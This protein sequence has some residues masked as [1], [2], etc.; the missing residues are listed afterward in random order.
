[1]A[2]G[3]GDHLIQALAELRA[4]HAAQGRAITA[5]ETAVEASLQQGL[6]ALPLP[7]A[8]V[9]A[10][11]R[12]HRPGRAPKI[13]SDPELRAFTAARI[14]RLTFDQI[15]ADIAQHFPASRHVG[16]STIWE[17]RRRQRKAEGSAIRN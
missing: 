4:S 3:T 17:W 8:P 9:S 15:A 2:S 11:R 7:S 13:D 1:M 12:E 14:D 16:R 10:H 6:N 5:L